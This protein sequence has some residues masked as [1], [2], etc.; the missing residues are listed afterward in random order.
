MKGF[1]E[2]KNNRLNKTDKV[3]III[4]N[5]DKYRDLSFIK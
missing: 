4:S 3:E 5:H 2:E 1:N